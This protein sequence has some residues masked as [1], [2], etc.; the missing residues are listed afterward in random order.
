[1]TCR[2][3]D[4]RVRTEADGCY[5]FECARCPARGPKRHS[6]VLAA[7]EAEGNVRVR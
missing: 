2:H 3:R 1:M 5:W 4:L 6:V 7:A